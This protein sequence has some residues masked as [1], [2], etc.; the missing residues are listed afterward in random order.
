MTSTSP[1]P[2]R[3]IDPAIVAVLRAVHATATAQQLEFF[4]AGALARDIWLDYIYL[5]KSACSPDSEPRRDRQPRIG[6]PLGDL[7]FQPFV[8]AKQDRNADQ[9]N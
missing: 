2:S 6:Q 9:Q 8:S 1:K 3:P 7:C 5:R 4:V